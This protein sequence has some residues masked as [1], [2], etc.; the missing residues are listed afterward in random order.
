MAPE[1]GNFLNRAERIVEIG[2]SERPVWPAP[3]VGVSACRVGKGFESKK[4]ADHRVVP[5]G[6]LPGMIRKEP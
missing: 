3:D 1:D 5:I 6:L 2:G 4:G